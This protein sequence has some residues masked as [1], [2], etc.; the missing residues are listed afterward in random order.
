MK[1]VIKEKESARKQIVITI[2][3]FLTRY[4]LF[5]SLG[6]VATVLFIGYF[7]LI[8]S[9]LAYVRSNTETA[10]KQELE[11]QEQRRDVLREELKK[12]QNQPKEILYAALP[13]TA[14]SAVLFGQMEQLF[15]DVGVQVRSMN[16]TE[17]T[18]KESPRSQAQSTGVGD[19]I[20]ASPQ[21]PDQSGY[22]QPATPEGVQPSDSSQKSARDPR[23][24]QVKKVTIDL[25]LSGTDYNGF[26]KILEHIENFERIV[27]VE[28]T[29]YS[30]SDSTGAGK[31]KNKENA[32]SELSSAF[33][34]ALV[35]YY[36][37]DL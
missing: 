4:F 19:E 29:Q 35:T 1:P 10:L 32:R 37:P 18:V 3:K 24:N 22:Q 17:E 5:V 34:L 8:K 33:S 9:P 6:V 2:G 12:L 30:A 16:I 23:L 26:K 36:L 7:F 25:E 20:N 21:P 14:E 27:E 13:Q 28:S 11:S 31:E 15:N